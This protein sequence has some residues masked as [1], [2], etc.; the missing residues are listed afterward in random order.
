[1]ECALSR[2]KIHVCLCGLVWTGQLVKVKVVCVCVS[3]CVCA[4]TGCELSQ[5]DQVCVRAVMQCTMCNFQVCV[6]VSV[7]FRLSIESQ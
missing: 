4:F 5:G 3:V 6:C 2:S 7:K 1:M